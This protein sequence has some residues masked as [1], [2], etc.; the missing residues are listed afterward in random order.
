VYEFNNVRDFAIFLNLLI[1]ITIKH[2]R[3]YDVYFNE[4]ENFTLSKLDEPL[5]LLICAKEFDL[6]NS[7]YNKNIGALKNIKIDYWELKALE[8]KLLTPKNLLLNA[9]ADRTS[10]GVSYWRFR[11][12]CEKKAKLDSKFDFKLVEFDENIRAIINDLC[13]ARNYEHHMTDA[14]FIEWRKY[15]EKQ[16]SNFSDPESIWPSEIIQVDFYEDVEITYLLSTYLASKEL[17]GYFKQLLQYM[18]KDYSKLI[19]KS[20][21]INKITHKQALSSKDSEISVNGVKRHEGKLH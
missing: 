14:K 8:D 1:E 11:K 3:K 7:R 15:R 5:K 21:S 4:L 18:K 19:G 17:R 13:S 6:E 12:E 2:L 10:N 20:M 9:F 16:L